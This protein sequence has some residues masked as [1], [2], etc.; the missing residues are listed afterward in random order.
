MD[1]V[2]RLHGLTPYQAIRAFQGVGYAVERVG[3][4]HFVLEHPTRPPLELPYRAIDAIAEG[5]MCVQIRVAGFTLDEFLAAWDE[6]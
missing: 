5:L 2:S 4:G 1:D 6:T 3:G